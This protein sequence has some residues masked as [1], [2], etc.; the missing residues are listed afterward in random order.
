M[1]NLF[2]IRQFGRL[3]TRV[4]EAENVS[5]VTEETIKKGKGRKQIFKYLYWVLWSLSVHFL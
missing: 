2:K 4:I 3:T 1:G 5:R